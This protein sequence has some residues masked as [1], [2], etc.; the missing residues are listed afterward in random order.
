MNHL[1]K[2]YT[3]ST[4][5][6]RR[7][8]KSSHVSRKHNT[9][10]I[11][12]TNRIIYIFNNTFLSKNYIIIETIIER[13]EKIMYIVKCKKTG[14]KLILKIIHDS[15]HKIMEND[16]YFILRNYSHPN[17]IK[18]ID[19]G[20]FCD[21]DEFTEF[22]YVIYEYVKGTNLWEFIHHIENFNMASPA[23][24]A[25]ASASSSLLN[26]TQPQP[27]P[28]IQP[29]MK[30]DIYKIFEQI[31]NGV[32]YLHSF[33][34]VHCDLKLENIVIS[35]DKLNMIKI[36]DF[37]LSFV[38]KHEEGKL[39]ENSFGTMKYIAP[40]SYDLCIYSKKSD[41]WQLGI[42]LFVM[43]TG[44]F[45]FDYDILP[46]NLHSNLYR[47]NDF[48]HINLDIIKEN[49]DAGTFELIGSMLAFN[50]QCRASIDDVLNSLKKIDF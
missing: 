24:L 15:V 10:P 47:R 33:N 14:G 37:D 4:T 13:I 39:F 28:Q 7:Y 21:Y 34:I 19:Y 45:P 49:Y 6:L 22:V 29:H 11:E 44:K 31:A 18:Y 27:Q 36:I 2:K 40:E 43:L 12:S 41:I 20:T 8:S 32:K 26:L 16:V 30:N 35:D 23:A 50:D 38:A 25:L 17:I 48:K 46:V 1:L 3:E 42:V 5:N 9:F